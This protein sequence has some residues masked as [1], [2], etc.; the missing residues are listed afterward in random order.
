MNVNVLLQIVELGLTEI[1]PIMDLAARL[2]SIFTLNPNVAVSIQNLASDALQADAD[3]QQM[4]ADWQKA[5]GL[6]ITPISPDPAK[7]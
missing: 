4:I 6:P 5:H 1:V 7:A 2:K 3:T